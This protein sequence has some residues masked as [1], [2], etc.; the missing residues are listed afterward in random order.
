MIIIK[1]DFCGEICGEERIKLEGYLGNRSGITLP[2]RFHK[3]DFCKA[4]CFE[5]WMNL[6]FAEE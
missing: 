3:K 1:C 6:P 5:E 4:K 2:D